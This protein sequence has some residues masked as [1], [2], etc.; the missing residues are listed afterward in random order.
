[1]HTTTEEYEKAYERIEHSLPTGSEL[2]SV[3]TGTP[4]SV[5][6]MPSDPANYNEAV[7][8]PDAELWKDSMRD[9]ARSLIDHDVFDWTDPPE[10]ATPIPANSFSNGSL[11]MMVCLLA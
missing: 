9:E 5:G 11:T 7:S 3:G 6:Y 2:A 1:M 4:G 8:G 10:D